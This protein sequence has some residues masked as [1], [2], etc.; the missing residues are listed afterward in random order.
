MTQYASNST[1]INRSLR[2]EIQALRGLAVLAVA[3]FHADF[4]FPG[5]FAGVD[6]FFVISGYVITQSLIKEGKEFRFRSL[7]SFWVRRF[8]RLAPSA[9]T[10]IAITSIASIFLLDTAFIPQVS[11]VAAGALL[12]LSNFAIALTSGGYF[13][14]DTALNPLLHTWSL[15][16]EDQFYIALPVVFLIW[17]RVQSRDKQSMSQKYLVLGLVALAAI[18][19]STTMVNELDLH[20]AFPKTVTGFYSPISRAWEFLVGCLAAFLAFAPSNPRV[21]CANF[22]ILVSTAGLVASFFYLSDSLPTP[23]LQTLL[24]VLST[25]G[26][27][28]GFSFRGDTPWMTLSLK[29]LVW[30]GNRSYSVYLWHWPVIV[31]G[32]NILGGGWLKIVY[33]AISLIFAE[34]NYRIVESRFRYMPNVQFSGF[35]RRKVALKFS[36]LACLSVA[37]FTISAPAIAT[38]SVSSSKL[39]KA[40]DFVR[41]TDAEFSPEDCTFNGSNQHLALLVGDSQAASLATGIVESLNTLGYRT[42]VSSRS[43]CPFLLSD[44]TGQKE[45]NCPSWQSEILRY[46]SAETPDLVVVANRSSGYTNLSPTWRTFTGPEGPAKSATVAAIYDS[47]LREMMLSLTA[48]GIKLV[49][50]QNIPEPSGI[51]TNNSLLHKALPQ[52]IPSEFEKNTSWARREI[53]AQV[54]R[55]LAEKIRNLYLFDPYTALCRHSACS[56]RV[57]ENFVYADPLHLSPFG[58]RLL[59]AEFSTQVGRFIRQ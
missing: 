43:G 58:S 24:P 15:S 19:F 12:G 57:G 30:L 11:I 36:L 53:A 39:E 33:L 56:Y 25:L 49:L 14:P 8:F 40:S 37:A 23:G 5:G 55:A 50:I 48:K 4:G 10:L 59:S 20:T 1:N 29:P 45:L 31:L 52:P 3:L 34:A 2:P 16:V 47:A 44:T 17:A 27:L 46:A 9:L 32:T 7:Q 28:I 54:E 51:P 18:S 42:L 6:I 22:L 26:V 21:R 41:C 13:D 38:T 35:Q